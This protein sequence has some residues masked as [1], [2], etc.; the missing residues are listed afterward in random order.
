MSGQLLSPTVPGHDDQYKWRLQSCQPGGGGDDDDDGDDD[1]EGEIDYLLISGCWKRSDLK[2]VLASDGTPQ[3]RTDGSVKVNNLDDDDLPLT[4]TLK[5]KSSFVSAQGAAVLTVKPDDQSVVNLTAAGPNCG[6]STPSTSPT[7]TASPAPCLDWDDDDVCNGDDNCPAW[8]NPAQRWP[9]WRVPAGDSDCDGF[10]DDLESYMTTDP[11]R[12]CAHDTQPNNEPGGDGWPLDADDN[13][14]ANILDIG[15]YVFVLN[16]RSSDP[17]FSPRFDTDQS[18]LIST[19]DIG[20][21]VFQLNRD[22]SPR[23]E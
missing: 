21:Y 20:L 1:D 9:R 19:I 16:D 22:C 4:V 3:I 14:L 23:G 12:H 6:A 11:H 7:A 15:N 18:G 5:F 13:G 10:T 2:S 17:G 8:P